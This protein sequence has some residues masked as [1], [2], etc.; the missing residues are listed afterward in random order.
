MDSVI[1]RV[2]NLLRIDPLYYSF[3]QN[4]AHEEGQLKPAQLQFKQ[5]I[6]D[7]RSDSCPSNTRTTRTK[8]D[9]NCASTRQ[10]LVTSRRN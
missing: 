8:D 1:G 6:I 2:H 4:G 3:T 9:I 7:Q 10:S 5:C